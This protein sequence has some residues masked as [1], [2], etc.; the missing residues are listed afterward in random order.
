MKEMREAPSRFVVYYGDTSQ[1]V[2]ADT[3]SDALEIVRNQYEE[4]W[5]AGVFDQYDVQ[6]KEVDAE[7]GVVL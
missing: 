4:E 2:I 1:L 6:V 5:G 7:E 3:P